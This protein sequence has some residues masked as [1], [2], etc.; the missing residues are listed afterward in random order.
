[1]RNT[2]IALGAVGSLAA[3][4]A[5]CGGGG[6]GTAPALPASSGT[7]A[8]VATVAAVDHFTGPSTTMTVSINVP[9]RAHASAA[10]LSKLKSIYGLPSAN[11]HTRSIWNTSP[12]ATVRSWGQALNRAAKAY[13]QSTRRVPSYIS[14]AT[15]YAEFIL[16][17][18]NNDVLVDTTFSCTSGAGNC[19]A[20]VGVPLGSGYTG[21]L[22]LY[23]YCG[24]L[25]SAGSTAVPT[26]TAAA[27]PTPS[28]T[29]TLNGVVEYVDVEPNP[30]PSTSPPSEP[31]IDDASQSQTFPVGVFP[32]DV[33]GNTITTPG[34]LVDYTLTPITAFD[35]T[36]DH[37]TTPSGTT[38]LS[39]N[40]DL[41]VPSQTY[42]FKGLGNETS[43]NW[44]VVAV[45]SGSPVAP[46]FYS[47]GDAPYPTYYGLSIAALPVQLMWTNPAGYPTPPGSNSYN[48]VPIPVPSNGSNDELYYPQF[49]QIGATTWALEFPQPADPGGN[50]LGI[51]EVAVEPSAAPNPIPFTG[52]INFTDNG[53]C[54]NVFFYPSPG[55]VAYSSPN[56]S[57]GLIIDVSGGKFSS[58]NPGPSAN[59]CTVYATDNSVQ[60]RSSAL[61]VYFDEFTLTVQSHA[62]GAK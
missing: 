22:F 57:Y 32:Y 19:S 16:S 48:N 52:S 56:P 29:V 24:Y 8:A 36:V 47:Y 45:T 9:A 26:I 55:P 17:D 44:S 12:S 3:A 60:Q 5:A 49:G 34:T 62:R 6:G 43:V 28:I 31:F 4:L 38:A 7:P 1:M 15:N 23:D 46:S 30:A 41:T 21:S 10:V 13:Q 37:D 18:A 11:A 59:P 42:T 58:P 50:I 25:I 40:A 51:Q 33:D 20:T 35:L 14:G 61:Q 2:L 27:S 53:L 54:N 39:V